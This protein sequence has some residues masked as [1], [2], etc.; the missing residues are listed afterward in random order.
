MFNNSNTCTQGKFGIAAAIFIYTK[1]GYNVSL[2]LID[3]QD[4]DI[5]IE[6]NKIFFTV[7]CKTTKYKVYKNFVVQLKKVRPNR[8]KN[9]I[10]PISEVD[11]VFVLCED[12]TMYNIP[13]SKLTGY[14]AITLS[15]IYKE[16]IVF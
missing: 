4:Y 11:F 14:S 3:N 16:F 5:V 2:P 12:N 13:F 7:Q 9:I 6:K 1:L 15:D 10:K 8:T